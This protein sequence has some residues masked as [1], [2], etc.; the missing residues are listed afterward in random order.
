MQLSVLFT[1]SST[2]YSSVLKTDYQPR[3]I[4]VAALT[5]QHCS[6]PDQNKSNKN[7]PSLSE[8]ILNAMTMISEISTLITRGAVKLLITPVRACTT[9]MSTVLPAVYCL[10]WNNG[11]IKKKLGQLQFISVN[12]TNSSPLV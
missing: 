1:R 11:K 3:S 6:I 12:S 10:K 8:G 9:F 2:S 5:S 7:V 4:H